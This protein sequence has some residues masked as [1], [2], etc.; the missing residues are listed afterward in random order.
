MNNLKFMKVSA[1]TNSGIQDLFSFVTEDIINSTDNE[2]LKLRSE[3]F[4]IQLINGEFF[5]KDKEK[6]KDLDGAQNNSPNK[7]KK[8][9]TRERADCCYKSL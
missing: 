7:G 2:T 1:L 4:K 5:N 3:S 9:S 8:N 6:G